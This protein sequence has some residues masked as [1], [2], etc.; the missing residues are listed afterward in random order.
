MEI[1]FSIETPHGNYNDSLFFADDALPT[2]EVVQAMMQVRVQ[3]WL[4]NFEGGATAPVVQQTEAELQAKH[5]AIRARF[6][7]VPR[8]A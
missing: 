2:D 7:E 3:Q 8:R 6:A 1:P 5:A 4:Q